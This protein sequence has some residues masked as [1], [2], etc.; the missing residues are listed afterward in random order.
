MCSD[1]AR[2]DLDECSDSWIVVLENGR[3]PTRLDAERVWSAIMESR[4]TRLIG[5]GW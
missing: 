5:C 3:Y 4:A 2:I 1:P